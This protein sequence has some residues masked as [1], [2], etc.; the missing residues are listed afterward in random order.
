MGRGMKDEAAKPEVTSQ[1]SRWA[2][3]AA[4][5]RKLAASP[6]QKHQIDDKDL[7]DLKKTYGVNSVTPRAFLSVVLRD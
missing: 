2:Q 6:P 5:P 7:L 3:T 1:A 4:F